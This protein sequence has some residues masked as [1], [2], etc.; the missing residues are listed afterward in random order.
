M[1][2]ETILITPNFAKQI[3]LRA[4]HNRRTKEQKVKLYCRQMKNGEWKTNTGESIKFDIN[5]SLIDGKHRLTALVMADVAI[6]FLVISDLSPDVFSVL[7]TGSTRNGCD[8]F[9]IVGIK[10]EN[11]MPSI[12][13]FNN[14]LNI[15]AV[16]KDI[17]AYQ[18]LTNSE[19]LNVYNSDEIFWQS[20]ARNTINWYNGFGKI[21]ATSAIGGFYSHF[22]SKNPIDALNFMNQLCYGTD[23]CVIVNNLRT[24]LLNDRLST[25]KLP[26]SFRNV[27]VIKAWNIF[28]TKRNITQLK[29]DP[30]KESYP[31][32]I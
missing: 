3:L 1:K 30:S 23:S 20:V 21:L 9:K 14:M 29:F 17:K 19:L 18:R 13:A 24:K 32:A 12:I 11:I 4:D 22:Y 5:G 2:T 25:K 10:N 6:E 16:N 31:S 7:D 28:R 15:G 26:L 27:L 8:T